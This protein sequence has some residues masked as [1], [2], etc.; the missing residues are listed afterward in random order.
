MTIKEAMVIV[1]IAMTGISIAVAS[2]C[3]SLMPRSPE[4]VTESLCKEMTI[5]H[6]KDVCLQ[7]LVNQWYAA[8]SHRSIV[9]E[10]DD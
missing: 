4:A 7:G 5:D 8:E 6:D 10:P 3:T 1:T 2:G 9:V